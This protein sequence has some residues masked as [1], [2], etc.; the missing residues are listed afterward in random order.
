M[1][2]ET[3]SKKREKQQKPV[4]S[5]VSSS[6]SGPQNTEA[7]HVFAERF[8][9]LVPKRHVLDQE[10][11]VKMNCGVMFLLRKSNFVKLLDEVSGRRNIQKYAIF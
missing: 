3:I 8:N 9:F 1:P 11:H 4:C 6:C 7:K 5:I 10:T 2:L